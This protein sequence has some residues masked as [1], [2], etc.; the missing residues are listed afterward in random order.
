MRYVVE[1][2]NTVLFWLVSDFLFVQRSFRRSI[3]RYTSS[4]RW[5]RWC[6]RCRNIL[7]DGMPPP[8]PLLIKLAVSSLGFVVGFAMFRRLRR[9]FYDYL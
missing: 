3:E 8:A 5:R 1:S 4:I 6:W 9:G 7:L 2:A